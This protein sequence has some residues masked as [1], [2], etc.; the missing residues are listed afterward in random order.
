MRIIFCFC[1]L[2]FWL[3]NGFAQTE[4]IEEYEHQLQETISD[5][6]KVVLLEKL[7]WELKDHDLEGAEKYIEEAIVLADQV[8][9]VKGQAKSYKTQGVLHWYK[10]ELS[11]AIENFEIALEKFKVI[12]DAKGVAN[13][14]NN[15][16]L[17]NQVNGDYSQAVDYLK[18]A[19]DIRVSINDLK[20]I[21]TSCNNLGVIY[22][23]LGAYD[24]SLNNHLRSLEIYR[25][26]E[27]EKSAARSLM[28]I[29]NIYSFLE[30]YEE[31]LAHF[32]A[33]LELVEKH[34]DKRGMADAFSNLGETYFRLDELED[35][36][37]Y[38]K[39]ALRYRKELKDQLGICESLSDLGRIE[40]ENGQI[41]ASL[42]YHSEAYEIA[43]EI[44]DQ[45]ARLTSLLFIGDL[46]K[47]TGQKDEAISRLSEALKLAEEMDSKPELAKAYSLQSEL[48]SDKGE[49][50]EALKM[51][52][53][54]GEVKDAMF[55][56]E[57]AQAL[58]RMQ[59]VY[60]TEQQQMQIADLEEDYSEVVFEKYSIMGFSF[61]LVLAG[62][63][64]FF[65]YRYRAELQT[66]RMLYSKNREIEKQNQQLT[67]N[68][69]DLEQYAYVVSHDLKQPLRTIGSFAGLI[70]RRYRKIL[71]EEGNEYLDYVVKGV[72][73]MHQLLSDLLAYT[74]LGK[75]LDL[76]Q[77][78]LN[79]VLEIARENLA[80]QIEESQAIISSDTLPI[81][82]SQESNQVLLFQNLISNAIRYSGDKSP[83]I[84]IRYL[85]E[86]EHHLLSFTDNGIGIEKE[87][88]KKIFTLFQQLQ[89]RHEYGG[90]GIG[91]TICQ[92]VVLKQNGEIWVESVPGEGSTFFIRFPKLEKESDTHE[93]RKAEL[94]LA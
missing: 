50:A 25:S 39:N 27:D 9:F 72:K 53:A 79:H 34:L 22:Q 37:K 43:N 94:Q 45:P 5:T 41:V 2:G 87:F 64:W 74:T 12:K 57:K 26:I 15:L 28:N 61:L 91:L 20:G 48:L 82:S 7:A 47:K 67:M 75:D 89:G 35:S 33:S 14:Y 40:E 6:Q 69:A 85:D 30:D 52:I 58:R 1:F 10:G 90:T 38:Y 92:K 88:Q 59:I 76:E 73:Q 17:A 84:D 78:D 11:S 68:N 66:S 36:E 93:W 51:Q 24:F 80:Y 18:K 42:S 31:A 13:V 86:G 21:A 70:E 65:F 16:G 55:D 3:S 8:A 54:Y 49:I 32:S 81:I 60:E 23:M 29:G 19:Y 62:L 4:Q 63:S 71:D 44:K 77:V 46:L 83:Q 56:E